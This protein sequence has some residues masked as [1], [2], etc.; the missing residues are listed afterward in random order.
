MALTLTHTDNFS[1]RRRIVESNRNGKLPIQVKS[2]RDQISR[3]LGVRKAG[4]GKK[5]LAKDYRARSGVWNFISV[6]VGR[7]HPRVCLRLCA[8]VTYF[9][10]VLTVTRID[11]VLFFPPDETTRYHD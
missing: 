3:R 8:I 7:G 4:E 6:C 5:K 1:A 2:T 11:G 9:L 10:V